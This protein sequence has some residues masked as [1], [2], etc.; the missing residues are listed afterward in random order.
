M[1][2][3]TLK[4][5]F[6]QRRVIAT[7]VFLLG[8][9]FV[10]ASQPLVQLKQSDPDL[11]IRD[12]AY[13]EDKDETLT[14][15]QI[16][17]GEVQFS[18]GDAAGHHASSDIDVYWVAFT[19]QNGEDTDRT[20]L[21]D[22]NKWLY[23]DA[24]LSSDRGIDRKA[25]TGHLI[26]YKERD[27][28]VSNENLVELKLAAGETVQCTLRLETHNDFILRPNDLNV[29][30]ADEVYFLR[31]EDNRSTKIA[32]FFGIFLVM[33]FYN[34]FI[35]LSTKD[36]NYI[37]YLGILLCTMFLT[38]HNFGYTVQ[39]FKG[40]DNY[41]LWH[42]RMHYI[43]PGFMAINVFMFIRGL[44]NVKEHYPIFNHIITGIIIFAIL[45]PIPS[46]LGHSLLNDKISNIFGLFDMLFILTI[47]IKA[48][49][50]KHSYAIYFL[51]GYG[52][53]SIGIALQ[54]LSFEGVV[55]EN[56]IN[57]NPLQIGS[58]IEVVMLSFALAS[59]IN[60][61]KQ[62]NAEKQERIIEHLRENELL[63]SKVQREL[64]DKVAERTLQI[65]KQKEEIEKQKDLVEV[66]KD[67]SDELLLNILPPAIADE[68]KA[69]GKAA[70]R[71][72]ES[73]SVIFT[74]IE[75]F[76]GI[77]E[78][79]SAGEL[80]QDLD[81]CFRN[82][83][84]ISERHGIVKIKTMGDAY[85][86]A[87]GVPVENPNHAVDAIRAALDFQSFMKQWNDERMSKGKEPWR[88]RCGVH[89]G[90]VT[91]GIVGKTKFAYDIW[92]DTVNLTSRLETSGEVGK[93][94]ISETTYQLVKDQF[95]CESRG[96]ITA[97]N[98]GEI[99]MYFVVAEKSPV[100]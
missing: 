51:I 74:D 39:I 18:R 16:R 30:V 88:I 3:Q 36:R 56:V 49:I 4:K 71:Y 68:L 53:F 66:E 11:T 69:H 50:D 15:Q 59:K 60:I 93:V 25:I 13:I 98:R 99:G 7:L 43:V 6:K 12:A 33:F 73:V 81:Y 70:P 82:F 40:M 5:L 62:E 54:L 8:F 64:E 23:V 72:Y 65:S 57:Y 1:D 22:L 34:F 87:S 91:A 78:G 47:A 42:A 84:E 24:Y 38:L 79:L 97:K 94:N 9:S 80:V 100:A 76:T 31:H 67:K 92:G 44:L 58:A 32:F 77:S 55:P 28:P 2:V 27:Y 52:A 61:L 26:P 29:R 89:S 17:S 41:A 35:F 45:L 20:W 10:G 95:D 90:P 96:K 63:Q 86:C 48:V 14:I 46:L 21:L 19:V 75:N 85:M 83:D 37:F